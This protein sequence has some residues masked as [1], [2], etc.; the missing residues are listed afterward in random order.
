MRREIKIADINV[1]SRH[2]KD[3]G[4]LTPP[5]DAALTRRVKEAGLS[6]RMAAAKTLRQG[7]SGG[8]ASSGG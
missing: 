5:G 8:D 1:G 6:F 3:M 7:F 4:D 2:R